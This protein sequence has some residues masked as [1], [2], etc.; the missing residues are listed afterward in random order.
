VP[1]A[2]TITGV[3]DSADQLASF[4]GAADAAGVE[5]REVQGTWPDVASD[6]DTAD[7]VVCHHVLYNVDDLGPFVAALTTHAKKRVVC[8]IHASHPMTA[9]REMWQHFHGVDRPTGPSAELA[10]EV[11]REVGVD[12]QVERWRRPARD[13]PRSAYVRLYRQRLC[14][15]VEAEPEVDRVL[16]PTDTPRDV[17][18]LWWN[19]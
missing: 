17:V 12:A 1:R 8:E 16:G 9:Y 2:A 18:T 7:V 5:H 10:V 11:L 4:A 3:D 6:V 13:V 14:L 15:P 19:T